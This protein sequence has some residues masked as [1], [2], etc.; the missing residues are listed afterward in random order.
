MLVDA[1]LKRFAGL[2][3]PVVFLQN[4]VTDLLLGMGMHDMLKA[5]A[6]HVATEH[7]AEAGFI[8]MNLPKLLDSLESVGVRNPIVCCNYNKI[9]FRMSGGIE[10]YDKALES[11][12]FRCIAMSVYASGAIEPEAAIRWICERPRIQSIVFGASSPGNIRHTIELVEKYTHT[13]V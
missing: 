10:A 1:E 12:E 13:A 5:F 3:V 7:K 11:R 8:T 2:N 6:D 9:G 4:V